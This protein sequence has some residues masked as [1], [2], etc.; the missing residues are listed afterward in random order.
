MTFLRRWRLLSVSFSLRSVYKVCY[1]NTSALEIK[2]EF[3]FTEHLL[4]GLKDK[5]TIVRWSAAKG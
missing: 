2:Y 5:E 3:H 4:V 1:R